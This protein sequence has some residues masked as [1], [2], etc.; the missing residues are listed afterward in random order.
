M[1]V[2]SDAMYNARTVAPSFMSSNVY[3]GCVP[4]CK[5][6]NQH[7]VMSE[8]I[9]I[10]KPSSFH[11][12][13]YDTVM[14]IDEDGSDYSMAS[15]YLNNDSV[16]LEATV[17][18]RLRTNDELPLEQR[19]AYDADVLQRKNRKRCN[20][21]LNPT[22]QLKK[23]RRGGGKDNVHGGT[24]STKDY[25]SSTGPYES[26]VLH[27]NTVDNNIEE[28]MITKENCCWTAGNHDILNNSNYIQL[29]NS[30]HKLIENTVEYEKILF[31]THG[32][33]IYQ[34]HRL[35]LIDNNCIETEF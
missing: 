31:E 2:T 3:Y 16:I 4:H 27:I 7:N 14:E 30:G 29:F 17:Q 25:G 13:S 20:S 24:G 34:F 32:C 23:F 28:S 22:S 21:D 8:H 1:A 26:D 9:G 19:V 6:E 18:N 33:S 15:G 35:Q 12:Y 11:Y 10:T 5:K